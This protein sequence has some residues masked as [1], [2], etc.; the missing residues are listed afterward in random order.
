VH[1]NYAVSSG[2][3][4]TFQI[5]VPVQPSINGQTATA[6]DL[7]V[8]VL[9][10]SNATLTAVNWTTVDGDFNSGWRID[11]SGG[12]GEYTV[13]LSPGSTTGDE[14]FAQGFE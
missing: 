13:V 1:D 2:T 11:V 12:T 14:I 10:P 3:T 9:S 4:A 7:R 5:N 8:Q 6:G